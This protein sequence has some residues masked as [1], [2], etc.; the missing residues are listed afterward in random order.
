MITYVYS[1]LLDKTDYAHIPIRPM[2]DI[3]KDRGSKL[4]QTPL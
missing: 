2:V 1:Q 4:E 3:L